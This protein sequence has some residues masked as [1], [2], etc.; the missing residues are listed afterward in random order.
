MMSRVSCTPEPLNIVA[1]FQVFKYTVS[2]ASKEV[3]PDMS[4]LWVFT[5]TSLKTLA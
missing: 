5:S 4:F 3:Q 1:E 2:G